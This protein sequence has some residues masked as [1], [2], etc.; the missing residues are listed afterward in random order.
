MIKECVRV[1]IIV[2]VLWGLVLPVSGCGVVERQREARAS[3]SASAATAAASATAAVADNIP[4]CELTE[5]ADLESMTGGQIRNFSYV[6]SPPP[7]GDNASSAVG[8]SGETKSSFACYVRYVENGPLHDI[9]VRYGFNPGVSTSFLT[10]EDAKAEKS[11]QPVVLDGFEGE[12][13]IVRRDEI[14]SCLMWRFP[15]DYYLT[16]AINSD[17]PGPQDDNYKKEDYT[18]LATEIAQLVGARV[19]EVA[20]GPEQKLTFYPEG[21]EPPDTDVAPPLTPWPS[22]AG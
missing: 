17:Q 20:A 19:L 2:G 7:G 12:G 3:A 11:A 5:A 8:A 1:T 16:V 10:L 15:N 6:H 18:G 9:E 13:V 22:P 21:S 4:V 14:N